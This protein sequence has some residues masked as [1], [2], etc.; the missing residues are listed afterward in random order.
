MKE[1]CGEFMLLGLSLPDHYSA[2]SAAA[3][4]MIRWRVGEGNGSGYDYL[5]VLT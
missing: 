3:A 4:G 1:T 2:S 5:F